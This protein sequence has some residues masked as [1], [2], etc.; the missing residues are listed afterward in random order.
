MKD[1]NQELKKIKINDRTQGAQKKASNE[2]K[3]LI[4]NYSDPESL[5]S[6]VLF[7]KNNLYLKYAR[8]AMLKLKKLYSR[9]ASPSLVRFFNEHSQI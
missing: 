6:L 3:S 2:I 8:S 4:Q 9:N 1:V 5:K 7:C